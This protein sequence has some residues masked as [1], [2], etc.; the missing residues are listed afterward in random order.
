V[1][2]KSAVFRVTSVNPGQGLAVV[3]AVR[4]MTLLDRLRQEMRQIKR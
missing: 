2:A 3:K 4:A 1:R